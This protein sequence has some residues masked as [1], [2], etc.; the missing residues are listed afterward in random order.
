MNPDIARILDANINRAREALRV[1]E[2]YV[3][4]V[5]NDPASSAALKQF[6]HDFANAMQTLALEGLLAFRDTPGDVGTRLSTATEQQRADARD[7]F[8][9]AAKR[10]P[11]ALRSIEEY[12]KVVSE[13]APAMIESIRYRA[14][15]LEQ[16]VLMRGTRSARFARTLL[17]VIVTESLC[18]G[19]WLDVATQ[20]I[21]GG[22]DCIQL[23]EKGLDDGELLDRARQLSALCREHQVFFIMNDRPDLALLSDADGVHLGQTDMSVT[24]ARRIVGP[25]RLIGISTHNQAQFHGALAVFPDYIAA[26]PMFPSTTKPQALVPGPELIEYVSSETSIPIV[27]IGGITLKHLPQLFHAGAE[28]VC[29]C[30]AIIG[31]ED[32]ASVAREFT[33]RLKSASETAADPET[34]IIEA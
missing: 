19:H 21:K 3:R 29:V 25:D 33:S 13:H 10:L 6:R 1:M 22:A 5:L 20:A 11:E 31:A 4:F 7:V 32:P 2:E 23:R 8:I 30:S 28:R 9:A 18:R 15:E 12:S 17:Y 34:H 27:P 14:Y 16:R 26:G 24:D